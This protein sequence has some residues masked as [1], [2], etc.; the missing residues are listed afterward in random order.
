MP[1]AAHSARNYSPL[2]GTAR[3]LSSVRGLGSIIDKSIHYADHVRMLKFIPAVIMIACAV[4]C[5]RREDFSANKSVRADPLRS[6]S[7]T[8]CTYSIEITPERGGYAHHIS[9]EMSAGLFIRNGEITKYN[10]GDWFYGYDT[11]IIQFNERYIIP[12]SV[13]ATV[14]YL[15]DPEDATVPADS[16]KIYIT[17]AGGKLVLQTDRAP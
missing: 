11:S 13:G 1:V 17:M 4:S 10:P 16:V 2:A 8:A 7:D 15:S 6:Y 9:V 3:S 12:K 14:V 5:A